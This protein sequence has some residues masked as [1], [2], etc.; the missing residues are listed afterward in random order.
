MTLKGG[1]G[2]EA[3]WGAAEFSTDELRPL[4]ASP[5]TFLMLSLQ[6]KRTTEKE[7]VLSP[8]I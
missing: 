3:R 1:L 6:E 5:R 7:L 4:Q 8:K 2:G